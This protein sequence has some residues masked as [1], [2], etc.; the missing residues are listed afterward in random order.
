MLKL[1][2]FSLVELLVL[3]GIVVLLIG[4]LLPVIASAR[5]SAN[6]AACA[7]NLRQIGQALRAYQAEDRHW[8]AAR[9]MPLP[10]AQNSTSQLPPLNVVLNRYV[11][12]GS[13][14]YHCPAN[15]GLVYDRCAVTS[16]MGWGISYLY[17]SVWAARLRGNEQAMWDYNGLD[18]EYGHFPLFHRTGCNTLCLDGSV[19]FKSDH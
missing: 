7:S 9:V 8:P 10:F 18:S 14:V 11:S 17:V 13:R 15:D 1:K 12:G 6:I 16:P 4:V 5:R 19:Q 2:G 3:L